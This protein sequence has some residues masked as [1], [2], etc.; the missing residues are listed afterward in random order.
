[1]ILWGVEQL[2]ILYE[3]GLTDMRVKAFNRMLSVVTAI[4]MM[5]TAAGIIPDRVQAENPIIQTAY[6]A[7]PSP[8]IIGDTLYVFTTRDELKETAYDDWSYMNEWRCYSTKDM[9]NFTDLG[10]IAHA[11]T[12]DKENKSRENYRAWAQQVVM[13]PVKEDGKWVNKYFLYAPFSGTKIDVAVA[14]NPWGPYVDA[15]PGKFLIDGG[16]GGGN[17]DP[18][19]YIDDHGHPED[20]ENYDAYMYWGNPYLRYCKLTDDMLDVDPDT[21]G[22]GQLSDEENAIDPRFN[23][24]DNKILGEVRPGLHSF[25]TL[26][27]EGYE[28]FGIPTQGKDTV[29]NDKNKYPAEPASVI[30][31][32]YQK[33]RSAFEE[34]PW[35]Y[36]HDDGKEG[37]DDYFLVFVG[38]RIPGE[39]IEYSTA[40]SPLGPWTYRGLIMN[41]EHGLSCL[42]PGIAEFKGHNYLFFLNDVLVGGDGSN[43]SVCVKEFN[44]D[45][46]NLIVKQTGDGVAALMQ[47]GDYAEA[48]K[49]PVKGQSFFSVE[50][51]GKLNPYE[52]NQAET[53]CWE[54]NLD[55]AEG[56]FNGTGRGVK[57]KAK[58]QYTEIDKVT[59]I[60]AYWQSAARNGV[61]VCDIDNDDYIK[62]REVDFGSE[63]PISFAAS[64][65][66]GAGTP[67][68]TPVKDYNGTEM[69]L[70]DKNGMERFNPEADTAGGTLEIWLDYEDDN[71]KKMIGTIEVSDTGG[72]NVYK[73]YKIDITEKV[74]GTH[75]MYFIFRGEDG[76][77]LFN[78]DTW[79]F[80]GKEVPSP[81]P[82]QTAGNTSANSAQTAGNA[83]AQPS[84][85][86]QTTPQLTDAAKQ[87]DNNAAELKA[88]KIKKIKGKNKRINITLSKVKG[89]KGY[90]VYISNGKKG[91]YKLV[92][93]LKSSKLTGVIKKLKRNKTYYVRARAYAVSEGKNIYS[94][95]SGIK[96]VKIK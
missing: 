95:F 33:K 27:D 24:D 1:M 66:C 23:R 76:A 91:A 53:I 41:R 26:G 84:A 71:A 45:D 22:D 44:Y 37:T 78:F 10:Q 68:E 72:T 88:P 31:E 81:A 62:V 48:G 67:I 59:G 80:T 46:D 64:I 50:P 17:I 29:D 36:K 8:L 55:G 96:K 3:R 2:S 40:P 57:T 14:D 63:G 58:E 90:M 56:G 70:T 74:T 87:S 73:D 11:Q 47:W 42:H 49:R 38:G 89:A 21:D 5:I 30:E 75:D 65:A 52:L 83:S 69:P 32:K 77:K 51:V 86:P 28:S 39:T 60:E 25:N 92:L 19:V 9:I 54:S 15:T 16:W 6:T 13:R 18:T 82:S 93:K 61:V 43:R 7:D 20:I 79:Q 94:K 34:G 4:T 35:L 85:A 12:F